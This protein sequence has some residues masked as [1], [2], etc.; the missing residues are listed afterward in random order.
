MWNVINIFTDAHILFTY[1]QIYAS[2]TFFYCRV[3]NHIVPNYSF[4]H[5]DYI[6][7]IIIHSPAQPFRLQNIGT[8]FVNQLIRI[9]KFVP[10]LS[11]SPDTKTISSHKLLYPAVTE[12]SGFDIRIFWTVLISS[13]RALAFT[14]IC[15][16]KPKHLYLVFRESIR[17]IFL[18]SRRLWYF[19]H[20][21]WSKRTAL[22]PFVSL[23]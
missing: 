13:C 10:L 12:V 15:F 21:H 23:S 6:L 22:F 16:T 7:Q 4:I 11:V 18:L 8:P 17:V 9:F 1:I 19:F 14:F 2:W 20:L 3:W 5:R